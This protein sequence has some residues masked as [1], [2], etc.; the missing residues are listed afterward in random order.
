M[1]VILRAVGGPGQ[2][3]QF[4]VRRGQV[5]RVGRTEWADFCVPADPAM[6]DV[7]FSVECGPKGCR[8]RALGSSPTLVNGSPVNETGLRSGDRVTA[9]ATTFAVQVQGLGA[10]PEAAAPSPAAAEPAP[11]AEA[12]PAPPRPAAETYCQHLELSDEARQ[13]LQPGLP[14]E[15]YLDQLIA[16]ELFPD[17]L[18]FV[19][20]WLPKPQA[21]RWAC[22]CVQGVLGENLTAGEKRAFDAALCWA[23]EPTEENRRAAEAAAEKNQFNGPA[24]WLALG[25][26]WS[27]GSLAPSKL[28]EAPAPEGL[29]SQALAAALVLA[30][31]RVDPG[32]INEGCREFL[33]QGREL[34]LGLEQTPANAK[35]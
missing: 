27:G 21:V 8:L 6:S 18:R 23:A 16:K 24:G 13:L 28:P 29:T 7:H 19:A 4:L 2:G 14:P 11:A 17:G 1:H 15:E 20:G 9:G 10:E 12:A 22:Y 25:A 34:A 5:A 31:A 30:A 26:F 32:R 35:T 3:V 33:Q